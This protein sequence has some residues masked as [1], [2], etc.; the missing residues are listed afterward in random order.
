MQIN[1]DFSQLYKTRVDKDP[2]FNDC[3][4]KSWPEL[5]VK[6]LEIYL[7]E[8]KGKAQF[9]EFIEED[10]LKIALSAGMHKNYNNLK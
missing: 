1:S 3:L 9:F 4:E 2:N 5:S 7:K 10:D 8:R 6:L